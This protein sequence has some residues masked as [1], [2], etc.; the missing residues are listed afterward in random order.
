[1]DGLHD[2]VREFKRAWVDSE[3]QSGSRP[4]G[5]KRA[6]QPGRPPVLKDSIVK[7]I[8]FDAELRRRIEVYAAGATDS[9]SFSEAVRLLCTTALDRA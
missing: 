2:V 3:V 1:M 9:G 5:G 7:T 4:H 8:T 6:H